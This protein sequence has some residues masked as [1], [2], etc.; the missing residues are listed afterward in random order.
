MYQIND[1]VILETFLGDVKQSDIDIDSDKENYSLLIGRCGVILDINEKDKQVL[2]LF[3]E[4]LDDLGL[5]NHN[6]IKNSLWIYKSDI[7]KL[8]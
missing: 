2:I 7:K 1:R 5:I 4:S 3:D 8:V 6:D